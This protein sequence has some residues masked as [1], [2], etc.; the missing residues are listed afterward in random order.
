MTK[1]ETQDLWEHSKEFLRY[2]EVSKWKSQS[3][4]EKMHYVTLGYHYL[5]DLTST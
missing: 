5:N 3:L 1:E 2:K 4:L